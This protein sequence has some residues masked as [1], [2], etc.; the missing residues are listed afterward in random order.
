MSELFYH[1]F[2]PWQKYCWYVFHPN[3]EYTFPCEASTTFYSPY[4]VSCFL[5]T[6]HL[7]KHAKTCGLLIENKVEENKQTGITYLFF[8]SSKI[9]PQMFLI[10]LQ[11]L[12]FS[13]QCQNF[14]SRRPQTTQGKKKR[15]Q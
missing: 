15:F 9:N 2:S 6:K 4:I 12:D 13:S 5:Q 14:L 1:Y 3:Q 8:G 10:I 11:N 7:P